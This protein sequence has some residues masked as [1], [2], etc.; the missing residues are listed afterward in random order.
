LYLNIKNYGRL[1]SCLVHLGRY[2][3]AV[4][5]ARK[6]NSPQTWKEV[7]FACV[8]QREFKLAQL[9][10]LNIITSTDELNEVCVLRI[11]VKVY[12]SMSM[13]DFGSLSVHSM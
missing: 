5:A 11:M 8:D 12:I 10:G 13:S 7:C 2:S 1:A 9:C 4:D 6:A 3:E